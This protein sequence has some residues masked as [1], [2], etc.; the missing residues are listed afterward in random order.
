M[1]NPVLEHH[2]LAILNRVDCGLKE[3]TLMAEVSLAM[4]RHDLTT[5]E[6]EDTMI[7]LSDRLLVENW[8]NSL[9]DKVY[10]ISNGGR[11]ALK[12]L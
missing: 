8:E 6:F 4:D 11:D 2:I 5:L 12:G 9:G 10:G 1:R 3:K 7:Y